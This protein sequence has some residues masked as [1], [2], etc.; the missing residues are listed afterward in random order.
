MWREKFDL[1]SGTVQELSSQGYFGF[2]PWID[3]ER[4]LAGVLSV[5]SRFSRVM[6][7]YLELKKE[8]RRIV[9]ANKQPAFQ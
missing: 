3:A 4:N 2:S 1:S 9:P 8:I 6:P 5:Q 7:D